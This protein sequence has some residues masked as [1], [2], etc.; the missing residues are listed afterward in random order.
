MRQLRSGVRV[1]A[2]YDTVR[3]IKQ[4]KLVFPAASRVW[5][6]FVQEL[7]YVD[8]NLLIRGVVYVKHTELPLSDVAKNAVLVQPAIGKRHHGG[9]KRGR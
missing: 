9:K 1:E 3:L 7:A 6:G 4:L 8:D 2:R 5:N